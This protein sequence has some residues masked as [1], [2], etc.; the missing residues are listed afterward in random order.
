MPLHKWRSRFGAI[1]RALTEP[2][3]N[4]EDLDERRE[5]RLLTSVLAGAGLLVALS[6]IVSVLFD[7]TVSSS[8]ANYGIRMVTV[9]L[10]IVA[11]ALSRRGFH[12]Q[13]AISATVLASLVVV[14]YATW[15]GEAEG[16][17][18]LSFLIAPL[19]FSSLFLPMGFS[20]LLFVAHLLLVAGSPVFIRDMTVAMALDTP[21]QFNLL[22]GMMI[23][24]FGYY[25]RRLENER[26][27]LVVEKDEHYRAISELVSDYAYSFKVGPNNTLVNEWSTNSLQKLTGYE[28]DE[29]N[30]RDL[31]FP[32]SDS[33]MDLGQIDRIKTLANEATHGEYRIRTKEGKVRWVEVHRQ[34]IYDT[35]EK[36]VIRYYG[37]AR[38]ITDRK[39]AEEERLL[40]SI[41]QERLS[42]MSDFVLGVSHDFRN[43]AAIIE[44]SRYLLG[45]HLE[46]DKP[47][48]LQMQNKLDTMRAGIE[49]LTV[50]LDNLQSIAT[51][52]K[53]LIASCELNHLLNAVIQQMRPLC[54]EKRLFLKWLPY[55]QP[56]RVQADAQQI[57]NAV[58]HLL[59]NAINHTAPGGSISLRLF[60]T[61]LHIG[62]EVRDTGIGIAEEHLPRIFEPFFRVDPARSTETGGIGLG[63]SIVKLVAEAHRGQINVQSVI[64]EGSTFTLTLPLPDDDTP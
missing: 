34:P 61:E 55:D 16:R 19:L 4:V 42:L 17:S 10:L 47:D 56:L 11:Y 46:Q 32:Y 25:R 38:D 62:I 26:H 27:R 20:L 64:G 48:R 8:M 33:D 63:L 2:L 5:S 49:H 57:S 58:N 40:L 28:R 39:R 6:I 31:T 14:G 21:F 54:Q 43:S 45:K 3:N 22:V 24:L 51:L 29:V 1:W 35:N 15:A 41:Q 59:T 53:P 50:Q 36:R 23:L 7:S 60:R 44:T 52:V 18:T 12:R 30:F 13:V 37:V 9:G